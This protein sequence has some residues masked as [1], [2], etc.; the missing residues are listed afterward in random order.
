MPHLSFPV[1]VH[2]DFAHQP[3]SQSNMQNGVAQRRIIQ[4]SIPTREKG[5]EVLPKYVAEY[6]VW[7]QS[8][9]IPVGRGQGFTGDKSLIGGL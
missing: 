4:A 3:S 2:R 1:L 7:W 9:T 8:K 5:G 6:H